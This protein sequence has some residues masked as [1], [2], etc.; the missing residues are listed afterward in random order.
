MKNILVF[1][2]LLVAI[3]A[4]A[5]PSYGQI[6]KNIVNGKTTLPAGTM[7]ILQSTE[8]L[9]SGQ[10]TV[11]QLVHF[12]VTTHVKADGDVVISTGALGLGRIKSIDPATFNNPET[13]HIEVTNV[14][15][16]DGQMVALTGQELQIKGKYSSQDATAE[17]N[18]TITAYV[19]NDIK[20]KT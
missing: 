14:Q 11:G 6:L 16:V 20:I 9:K 7:V 18:R 3:V 10:A 15:A 13:F 1:A 12:R 8:T 4:N 19:T 17:A 2:M 5:T